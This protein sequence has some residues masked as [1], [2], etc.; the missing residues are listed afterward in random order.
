MQDTFFSLRKQHYTRD[1]KALKRVNAFEL[2]F[3]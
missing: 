2:H 3:Y 1:F